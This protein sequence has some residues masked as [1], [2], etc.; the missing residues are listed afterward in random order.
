MADL[1]GGYTPVEAEYINDITLDATT[2]ERLEDLKLEDVD[3]YI[4]EKANAIA[5]A[6]EQRREKVKSLRRQS[7]SKL[8]E[9]K[10]NSFKAEYGIDLADPSV[11]GSIPSALLDGDWTP[12][13][14]KSRLDK[15]QKAIKVEELGIKFPSIGN[16]TGKSPE[17]ETKPKKKDASWFA[18]QTF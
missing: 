8:V 5:S 18:S 2:K 6:K 9:Q 13:E 4:E 3:K 16:A 11:R 12:S 7:K 15:Y 10:Y 17:T 1:D 14:L